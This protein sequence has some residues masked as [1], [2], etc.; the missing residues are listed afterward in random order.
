MGFYQSDD[1]AD[2]VYLNTEPS[3]KPF[4]HV[5]SGAGRLVLKDV[6]MMAAGLV[7]A[8]DSA[9]RLNFINQNKH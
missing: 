1:Q 6:V 2:T 3:W 8:S 5:L 7:V 9:K 4:F